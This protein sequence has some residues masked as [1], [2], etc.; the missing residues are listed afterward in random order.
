[1]FNFSRSRSALV[2]AALCGSLVF[3]PFARLQSDAPDPLNN[4]SLKTMLDGM[5]YSPTAL[6]KGYLIA[7]KR[8]TWTYNMQLVLSGDGTKLGINANLGVV[9]DPDSV[10]AASWLKLLQ[11]NE[12]TDPT[13]F[14]F[15]KDQ[16]KLYLHRVLDNRSISAAFLRTQIDNFCSNIHDTNEDWK[17]T[18]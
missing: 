7:I 9:D 18:K 2:S 15:D 5:G 13:V 11:D 12:D 17:F 6:S 14:Y 4:D 16:K 10:G 1:M 3:F 8:D